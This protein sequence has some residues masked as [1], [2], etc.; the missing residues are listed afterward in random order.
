MSK[1]EIQVITSC[2]TTNFNDN[3]KCMRI[4]SDKNSAI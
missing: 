3:I 2:M 1:E 4:L